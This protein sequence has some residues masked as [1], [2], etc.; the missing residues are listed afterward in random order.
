MR[1]PVVL[2]ALVASSSG[3]I[4]DWKYPGQDTEADASSTSTSETTTE[5]TETTATTATTVETSAPTESGIT[6]DTQTETSI[7]ETETD[8]TTTSGPFC[9]N[10]VCEDGED[11]IN[12]E[13]D[14][15]VPDS[16]GD[17]VCDL[18]KDENFG[19]CPGDCPAVCGNDVV[20]DT[21]ECD[22]GVGGVPT[23]SADC[24]AD[25][26]AS[27]CG[28]GTINMADGEG[29][30][31]G[32]PDN[33]DACV[34]CQ[35]A[36]C[37]DGHVHDGVEECDDGN[38]DD[39]AC[40]SMCE[41]PRRTVFVTS[42]AYQGNLMGLDGADDKCQERAVTAMLGGQFKA[43][44]SDGVTGPKDRFDTDFAGIYERVDGTPVAA[45]WADLSDGSLLNAINMDEFGVGMIDATP[46]SN[47]DE[48][49]APKF[50][51]HCVN[52]TSSLGGQQGP[53]GYTMAVDEQWTLNIDAAGCS[54]P[55]PL[56]CFEDGK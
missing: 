29:C 21:E 53:Q 13:A 8:A 32:N 48:M 45:G 41:V 56:Y 9:G 20:E 11:S 25:C 14:C 40:D 19:N 12:C 50:A 38:V 43:W 4:F 18:D 55:V 52:W 1:R 3:C 54:T 33:G 46:W 17:N 30:D 16:C 5:P 7:S 39:N 24:D 36:F 28:D 51:K 44:L 15:P 2:V 10:D 37:G 22:D 42:T 26:T 6:M 23:E 49:G 34:M 35:T 31:D 27:A 47:T